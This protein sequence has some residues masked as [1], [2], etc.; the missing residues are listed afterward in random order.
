MEITAGEVIRNE[1]NQN[2][3]GGSERTMLELSKRLHPELLKNFQIIGSRIR[4]LNPD[5]F[6]IFVAHDLPGDPESDAA[7]GNGKW[8]RF[9]KI[10]FISNWQAQA[11]IGYYKIPWSRCQVIKY[12][13]EPIHTLA[14][15]P[16]DKIKLVYTPTPHR[17]LE[18]LVPAFEELC[19]VHEDIEL[20]VFSSFKLY[21]WEHR[22]EPYKP[23]FERIDAN[24]KIVNHGTQP[25][26]EIRK[27]LGHEAHIFAYPS[28]WQETFCLSLLEAMSA[29]LACVHPNFGCLYETAADWTH[30]YSFH[31]R[32]NDHATIFANVLHQVIE[33]TRN[34]DKALINLKKGMRSYVS[35][36][37]NWKDRTNEWN[38]LLD[39][40]MRENPPKDISA[41]KQMF[42]YRA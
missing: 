28:I 34:K 1:L 20:H 15:K 5:L 8:N 26:E 37:Y 12:A 13:I 29:G 10:I 2:A 17:G 32:A 39:Q 3:M 19:K 9:H 30:M 7:L 25:N 14:D 33:D 6:R 11:Y 16:L 18:L 4:E 36:F 23:L 41:P 24:P 31:E 35:T 38:G 21:G 22:D 27:F 42:T 40:I